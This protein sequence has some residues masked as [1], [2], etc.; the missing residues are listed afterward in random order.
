M[1]IEEGGPAFTGRNLM[2]SRDTELASFVAVR[3]TPGCKFQGKGNRCLVGSLCHEI[4]VP[5]TPRP[6]EPWRRK[7]LGLVFM[8]RP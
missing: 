6:T 3:A 2:E 5:L 8:R 4:L 7:T 1:L